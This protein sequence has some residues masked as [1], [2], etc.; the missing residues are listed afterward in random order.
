MHPISTV[1]QNLPFRVSL[2]HTRLVFSSLVGVGGGGL[3]TFLVWAA[4]IEEIEAMGFRGGKGF[5][6][7]LLVGVGGA[8]AFTF[9]VL[10]GDGGGG[11]FT[12]LVSA[13]TI[14][15]MKESVFA[16]ES[17]LCFSDDWIDRTSASS[18]TSRTRVSF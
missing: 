13:A 6:L 16:E 18:S 7:F 12:F 17:F 10:V 3:F 2:D 14:E 8:G 11:A 15:E 5:V 9:L 1:C 4:T